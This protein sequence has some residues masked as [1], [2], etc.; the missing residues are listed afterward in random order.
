MNFMTR[1]SIRKYKDIPVE[2][3]KIDEILKAALLAT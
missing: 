3:E 2:K 1:R